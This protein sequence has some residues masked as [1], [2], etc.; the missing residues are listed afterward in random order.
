M[1]GNC[2]RIDR[3][4]DEGQTG[5]D[6][7]TDP[8]Q[9]EERILAFRNLRIFQDPTVV[10]DHEAPELTVPADITVE[11]QAAGGTN[12]DFEVSATE[13]LDAEP[14][15]E[16]DASS[17]DS[18]PL[19]DTVVTC[20]AVDS[21]GNEADVC[22]FTVSVVCGGK[23][24]PG[25]F[26]DLGDSKAQEGVSDATDQLNLL[27]HL[28]NGLGLPPCEGSINSAANRA[29]L[30]VND[31]NSVDMSDAVFNPIHLLL[32]GPAPGQGTDCIAVPDCPEVCE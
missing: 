17:G 3:R 30:D 12:V 10:I 23:Q 32:A 18:F 15:V 14:K 27:E 4:Y 29:V 25:D 26:G 19:G 7:S 6:P 11:C 2:V 22:T 1:L 28:F 21:A 8:H 13:N 9:A 5:A 16:C 20:T 31:D 24:R